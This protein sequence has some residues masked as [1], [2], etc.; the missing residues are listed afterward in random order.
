[1]IEATKR[2][3]VSV[4]TKIL[5]KIASKLTPINVSLNKEFD[6]SGYVGGEQDEK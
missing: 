4:N 1:M 2:D 6:F 3:Q 5:E